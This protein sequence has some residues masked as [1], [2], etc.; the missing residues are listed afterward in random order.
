MS[1]KKIE[2]EMCSL[3]EEM[4]MW[5]SYRY[6]IGRKTYVNTLASYIAK[7]YYNILSDERLEFTANDI[8]KCI[9]DSLRFGYCEFKYEGSVSYGDRNPI[10]DLLCWLNANVNS[11]KDLIGIECISCY[12]ESYAKDS[13]KLFRT[14]TVTPAT[15][16]TV[17]DHELSDLLIW[18]DLASCFDKKN[19][20]MLHL[21]YNGKV[22]DV[23]CFESWIKDSIPCEDKPGYY[24]DKPWS[25]KKVWRSVKDFTTSGEHCGYIIDEAIKSINDIN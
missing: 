16:M 5:T 18:N 23:E 9:E 1:K 10:P 19:H 7:K 3:D 11:E 13:P 20:K 8:R 25:W 22:E 14:R 2:K 4:L 21:E 12:K 24:K 17:Y 6:C 15:R